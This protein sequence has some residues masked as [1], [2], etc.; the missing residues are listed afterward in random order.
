MA[1]H[2]PTE[3]EGMLS[4]TAKVVEVTKELSQYIESLKEKQTT[5]P[6]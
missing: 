6:A 4:D 3:V 5:P 1:T 2:Y